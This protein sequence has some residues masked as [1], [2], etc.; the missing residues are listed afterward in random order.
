LNLPE[1]IKTSI[2]FKVKF[3]PALDHMV[4]LKYIFN[5][6]LHSHNDGSKVLK[7]GWRN[8]SSGKAPAQQV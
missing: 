3:Y 6:L 7:M 1:N 2:L 8:G 4:Y 5:L